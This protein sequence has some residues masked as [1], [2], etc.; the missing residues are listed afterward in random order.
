LPETPVFERALFPWFEAL[1]DAFEGICA[2]AAAVL[3]AQNGLSPF[4]D[5]AET[6]RTGDYLGGAQP[7][8]DAYFFYRHG[9]RF[10]DHHQACPQTAAA[11]E[12]MPRVHI[13]GHAPE[14]CFSVLGASS[15]ILPHYGTSNIR[16]VVHLP[17]LVPE[18]CALK[19]LE[20]EIP[21]KAGTCFAFDDTFLHEAWNRSAATRVILLMDTWNPHLTEIEKIALADIV[22]QTGE[23]NAV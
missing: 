1:E 22:A 16:S 19:V 23:L 5:L 3:Q 13:D 11:L 20:S 14:I 21:G 12:A 18:G 2:E 15:H 8:W 17:L 7:A 10:D 6:D 9:A 4:L